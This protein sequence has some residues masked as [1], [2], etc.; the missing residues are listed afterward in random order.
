MRIEG[1][2]IFS[3]IPTSA[4][5]ILVTGTAGAGKSAVGQY[6]GQKYGYVFVDGDAVSYLLNRRCEEEPLVVRNEYLCHSEVIR[7]MLT[8]LGLGYTRLI[9]SYVI[10]QGELIRY[11][12]ALESYKVSY[13]IRVLVP[14]REV[15]L[16][17]DFARVGW[18]A[19]A[20]YVDKWHLGFRSMMV[21]HPTLCADTSAESLEET[22]ENH[23]APFLLPTERS[24]VV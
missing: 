17:R 14:D 16:E 9:V 22:V 21:T 18:R 4:S 6:I 7:I 1:E 15:C 13:T 2:A 20:E 23:F 10:E 19:G 12:S 8:V 5:V 24:E 11:Q 3:G